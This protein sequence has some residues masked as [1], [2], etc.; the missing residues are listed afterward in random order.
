MS[1]KILIVDDDEWFAKSFGNRLS[2]V[3]LSVEYAAHG[4]MAIDMIDA[5]KPSLLIIDLMLPGPNG[6]ALIH[7]LKS[8][9]DLAGIPLIV[10]SSAVTEND[11]EL[12][13]KY[14]ILEVVDKTTMRPDRLAELIEHALTDEGE[15]QWL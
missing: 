4:L 3:G 14:G 2:K 1:A 10:W 5:I 11:F 8:H 13:S 12:L 6:L 7:E 9:A 15:R